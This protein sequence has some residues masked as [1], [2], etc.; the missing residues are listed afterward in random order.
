MKEKSNIYSGNHL[1]RYKRCLHE[2]IEPM[3]GCFQRLRLCV[4]CSF[5]AGML[6]SGVF[7]TRGH[8]HTLCNIT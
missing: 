6:E 3:L 2:T 8:I 5:C 1:K 7:I 4:F